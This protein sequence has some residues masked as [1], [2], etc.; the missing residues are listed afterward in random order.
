[1]IKVKVELGKN[2]YDINIGAGLLPRVG[3]WLKEKGYSGKAVIITDTNVK[4]LYADI[5]QRSLANAAFTVTIL[6]V[7]AGED[8]KTLATAGRLYQRL[9]ESFAERTTPILALGGGVIGDLAGFVAA[10]YMRGVPLV[11]IPTSLLAMVDSSIG[12]K[13]AVDHANLK[14]MIG[15]FY[16]PKLV[17]AD[18]DTLKTL[19]KI[20]LSNGMGEVI[21]HAVIRDKGFFEFLKENMA[22]AMAYNTG[23]LE[24]IIE[25]N[26]RIKAPVV[27]TDEKE[28]DL[29]TILNF[30]HTV[31]HAVEAIS[32][33][34][35]KHGQAVAIGMMAAARISERLGFIRNEE[36][37]QLELLIHEAGLPVKVPELSREEREK[38]LETIKHDKKVL[39]NKIRFVL[40]KSIGSAIISDKVDTGLIGEV[41][42]GWR[43][44]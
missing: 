16:Q 37:N 3:L 34:K 10:T 13:T 8:Q 27:E 39:D 18:V 32:D 26:A 17:V 20:E 22:G 43:T 6:E 19:P 11:Q 28:S 41:L 33:F 24:D 31:G 35:I 21:K 25:K 14:N 7:P 5:L 44:A 9:A 12:G 36:V 29:R 42:F 23:L 4:G 15:A 40:L 2:S 38:L 1:M 30:G